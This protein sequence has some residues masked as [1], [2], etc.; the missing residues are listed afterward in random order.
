MKACCQDDGKA[1]DILQ[2]KQSRVLWL[3]L[4]INAVMF[5]VEMTAGVLGRSTALLGDSLDMLG[6]TMVY[7]FSLFADAT[8]AL[9]NRFDATTFIHHCFMAC[10][11]KI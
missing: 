11:G 6:D 1:L 4:Y 3:V 9:S 8:L 2:N 10:A 5:I 7:G